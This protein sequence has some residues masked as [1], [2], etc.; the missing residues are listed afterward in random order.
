MGDIFV[1]L[2]F[3]GYESDWKLGGCSIYAQTRLAKA[4]GRAMGN[5]L[6][7]NDEKFTWH[8]FVKV[9]EINLQ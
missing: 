4:Q 6:F 3:F 2:A 7:K 8:D 9:S 5:K 1:E